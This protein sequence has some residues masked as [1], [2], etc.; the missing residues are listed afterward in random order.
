MISKS[1]ICSSILFTLF[2]SPLS[3]AE[4]EP[5]VD[6]ERAEELMHCSVMSHQLKWTGYLTMYFAFEAYK[7]CKHL[8]DIRERN[9]CSHPIR[10]LFHKAEKEQRFTEADMDYCIGLLGNEQETKQ[11]REDLGERQRRYYET[12]AEQNQRDHESKSKEKTE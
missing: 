2:L 5:E 4:L 3:K 6:L 1:L 12:V 7:P 9:Q 11:I 8:K 10:S